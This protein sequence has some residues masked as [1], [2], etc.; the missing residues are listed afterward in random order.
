M[1][2]VVNRLAA[3]FAAPL[4]AARF[5]TRGERQL[6]DVRALAAEVRGLARAAKKAT[7]DLA[8]GVRRTDGRLDKHGERLAAV[9]QEIDDLRRDLSER[10]ERTNLQLGAMLRVLQQMHASADGHGGD[11]TDS[12]RMSGRA[13]PLS[14]KHEHPHWAPVIG[15]E[16]H[17]DANGKEWLVL[18][19]CPFCGHKERTVVVEWNKLIMLAKAPDQQSARYDYSC[20][21][22]CGVVYAA[23]RP[24]GERFLFLLQHFGEVTGKA[25]ADGVIPN[26]LL[27]PYPLSDKDKEQLRQ[28]AAHGVW[29][30]EH[31]GLKT[32]EYLEGALKDRFE[33]S[34]HV[35]LLANLVQPTNARVLE[36]RPRAG[37]IGE[38]LRRLYNANV[39]VMPMWESQKFLL[40][41]LYGFDADGLIDYDHFHIPF[42]GRFDLIVCNHILVHAV[43]PS[44]FLAEVHAH[45][46]PGGYVYLY[47]EPEDRQVLEEGKSII[48]HLNPLHMQTFDRS[49]MVRAL[50]AN[51]FDVT[52]IKARQSSFLV[53]ARA[54]DG[55]VEWSPISPARL[56]QRIEAYRLARDRAILRLPTDMRQRLGGEWTGAIEHGLASGALEF[57]EQGQ[58][59]F[60]VE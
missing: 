33:N 60:A 50:A 11:A 52:F 49:A 6:A 3:A 21:H 53:L 43:R 8:T 35:D 23:R 20:C 26:P 30:S 13:L 4:R 1:S 47:N 29:V 10:L 48:A 31:L 39:S 17:P 34:V 54:V 18:D 28:M 37:T 45:L 24:F 51:G 42:E 40:K 22:R 5:V 2:R 56:T 44:E 25:A 38:S 27:N 9:Q 41:E 7:G 16:V 14:V 19:A 58:L 32:T 46:N 55:P 36:I 12:K 59:R 15:G 57:D